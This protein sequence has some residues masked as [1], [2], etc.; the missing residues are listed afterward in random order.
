M[1]NFSLYLPKIYALIHPIKQKT[2][3]KHHR[4]NLNLE[5]HKPLGTIH[6]LDLDLKIK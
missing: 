3:M 1:I 2:V 4:K 6:L 5:F